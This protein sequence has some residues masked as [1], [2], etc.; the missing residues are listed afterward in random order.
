MKDA[1]ARI[2]INKLLEAAGSCLK[3]KSGDCLRFL[4]AQRAGGRSGK[5]P[6]G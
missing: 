6:V 2:K 5:L 3:D 1:T 4:P